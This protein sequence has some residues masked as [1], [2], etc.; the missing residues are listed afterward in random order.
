MRFDV[1]P[2]RRI[3]DNVLVGE[4][5]SY[6]VPVA[7]RLEFAAGP[8]WMVAAMPDWPDVEKTT[9]MADEIMVVFSTERMRKIGF[10]E[11]GS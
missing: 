3:R 8:V 6:Q 5:R 7:L 9:L 11:T 2:A 4:A 1:G 10:P